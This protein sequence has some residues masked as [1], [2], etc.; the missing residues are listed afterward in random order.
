MKPPAPLPNPLPGKNC[1]D[2]PWRPDRALTKALESDPDL[3]RVV[4][5]WPSLPTA[6]RRAV[7]A[8]ITAGT[9]DT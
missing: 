2:Q 8:L 3:A 7:L 9:G 5:A 1:G 6:I 4:K